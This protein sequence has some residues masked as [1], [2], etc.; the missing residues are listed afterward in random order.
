MD[1]FSHA[2]RLLSVL[3]IEVEIERGKR[4]DGSMA[5]ARPEMIGVEYILHNLVYCKTHLTFSPSNFF[6]YL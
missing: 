6:F 4:K 5:S 1:K 3:E 2:V